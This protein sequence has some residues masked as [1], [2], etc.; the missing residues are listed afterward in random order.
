MT[1]KATSAS[2][3]V[4]KAIAMMPRHA[5]FAVVNDYGMLAV[6]ERL[7]AA[8]GNTDLAASL[9]CRMARALSVMTSRAASEALRL[10]GA[11]GQNRGIER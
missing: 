9:R 7:A 2:A 3:E 4:A 1:H 6:R 5:T 11:G 10:H 8:R